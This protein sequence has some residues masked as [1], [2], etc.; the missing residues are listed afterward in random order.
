MTTPICTVPEWQNVS[1]TQFQ[2]EII[3]SNK[4]A[5]LRGLV[6]DWPAVDAGLSGS[7]A[8]ANFLRSLDVGQ[9]VYTIV[10]APEINGA[11]SYGPQCEGVN[12]ERR[13]ANLSATLEQLL[14][15]MDEPTPHAIAVQAA[16]VNTVLPAF[17]EHHPMPLLDASVAPTMWLGNRAMV[18]PH[19]DVNFNLAAVVS[20]RRTFTLFPP[21][22]V[23]NLYVG[24][25]LDSPG[26]V[27]TSLVDLRDPDFTR[28]PLF[29][30]ALETAL[31]ATL[32]PG[33]VI[34]IPTPW[35]HGVES[36]EPLN[37]L[38]NYWWGGL[39]QHGVSPNNSLMHSMLS[40]A[41]LDQHQRQAWRHLFDYFVFHTSGDPADHL[42]SS[43]VD[44][45]A[46][47][48]AEQRQR[49]FAFLKSR[50]N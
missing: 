22:Q 2:N 7:V 19:Y 8:T 33:D 29:K 32:D 10:G 46:N 38:I 27:P 31:V 30:Y 12:F 4:P 43:V 35:W 20:G 17:S 13:Q 5:I 47:L 34:Y 37:V 18:A 26:G 16:P 14:A 15:L 48:S 11:F 45:V 49:V 21:E 9:S 6:A 23:S 25:M 41:E 3:P 36:L 40:I 44:V 50:L 42:P 1:I 28:F 39:S 24:P